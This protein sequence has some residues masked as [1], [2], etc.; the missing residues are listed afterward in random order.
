[1]ADLQARMRS[2]RATLPTAQKRVADYAMSCPDRMVLQSV[3]EVARA[4]RVSVASVS[5]LPA[6]LGCSS[7][8]D[9]RIQLAQQIPA[10][11]SAVYECVGPQDSDEQ[12]VRKVFGGNIRSLQDTLGILN[13]GDL[14]QT[15][16]L[17]RRAR[18]VVFFG[19]GGSGNVAREAALR[20]AH[21]DVQAEAYVDS[22]QMLVQAVRMADRDVAVGISH[23]GRSSI[24]V[25]AL[26]LARK[27]GAATVGVSNYFQSPLAR[28]S[29]KFFA[30]SFPETR[31]KA[32]A[33]SSVLAQL[34]LIDALYLL[35]ARGKKVLFKVAQL[36]ACTEEILRLPSEGMRA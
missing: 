28:V 23:S 27:N 25:E 14:I 24:T 1:M 20:L 21:L 34:C 13:F 11:V 5:R 3:Y 36:D 9:F 32:A 18:R 31:V 10:S 6:K 17:I 16:R 8:K 7:F 4:A 15:A 22:Y 30:T 35:V 19:I 2:L 33:L 12:T 29:D 26:R